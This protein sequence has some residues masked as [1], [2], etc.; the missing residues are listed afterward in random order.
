MRRYTAVSCVATVAVILPV[1]GGKS[2]AAHRS[3]TAQVVSLLTPSMPS[4]AHVAERGKLPL[5][6]FTKPTTVPRPLSG[7]DHTC[8]GR[9]TL[10]SPW[11]KGGFDGAVGGFDVSLLG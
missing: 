11:M 5:P 7:P 6:A 1:A 9:A 4:S 10:G 2:F 3:R 8:S